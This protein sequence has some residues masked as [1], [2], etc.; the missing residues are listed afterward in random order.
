MVPRDGAERSGWGL[1]NQSRTRMEMQ[2]NMNDAMEMA[3]EFERRIRDLYGEETR[4]AQNGKKAKG[5]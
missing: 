3:M 2:V 5:V 4:C 1:R